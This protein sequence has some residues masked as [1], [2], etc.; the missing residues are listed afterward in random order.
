MPRNRCHFLTVPSAKLDNTLHEN[1]RNI[2]HMENMKNFYSNIFNLQLS[3]HALGLDNFNK[4]R[5]TL[6]TYNRQQGLEVQC[7]FLATLNH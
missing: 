5:K 6:L 4:L 2:V 3:V 7:S 1:L